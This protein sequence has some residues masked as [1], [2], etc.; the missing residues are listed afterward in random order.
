MKYILELEPTTENTL[1]TCYTLKAYSF[2]YFLTIDF[3]KN[4]LYNVFTTDLHDF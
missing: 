3:T 2:F 4:T 1:V